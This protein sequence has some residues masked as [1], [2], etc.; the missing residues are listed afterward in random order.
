MEVSS[1]LAHEPAPKTHRFLSDE[2]L[3]ENTH[4]QNGAPALPHQSNGE[5]RTTP[6]SNISHQGSPNGTP[7]PYHLSP[8][9]S[10]IPKYVAFE[11]LFLDSP[12]YRARLPMRVNIFPH[13]TTDSIVTT[14][15]NF[16]GLYEGPGGPKGISFEDANGNTLIA[17][18]ENFSSNMTVFVRVLHEPEGSF[19]GYGPSSRPSAS[20]DESRPTYYLGD[21]DQISPLQP[22]Q[23]L[24]YGQPPSRPDSRVARLRSQSPN[25][26]RGR[27]SVSANGKGQ[28]KMARS[29]SGLKSRGSSTHGLVADPLGDPMHTYSSDDGDHEST[30]SSRK[31]KSELASAEISL[32]NIVEGG[33][34]KRAKFE[35]SELPLFVPP[36]IPL[37]AS[38]SSM[39]PT[40]QGQ[41]VNGQSHFIHPAHQNYSYNQ[42]LPSPM[43]LGHVPMTNGHG[44]YGA[45]FSTPSAP[46]NRKLRN[47]NGDIMPSPRLFT[48]ASRNDSKMGI[49]PTPDPTVAST[50]SDEDVALQL[51]RL[52]EAS[53]MSNTTRNSASTLDDAMSGAADAASSGSETSASEDEAE[54][55]KLPL[56]T[57]TGFSLSAHDV[58]H[59]QLDSVLKSS[60]SNYP[61]DK[62]DENKDATFID[63]YARQ[64]G[65][66]DH[67]K[68]IE[69]SKPAPTG[70]SKPRINNTGPK[71]VK[72]NKAKV[73]SN[74]KS[75]GKGPVTGVQPTS[76]AASRAVSAASTVNFQQ[77][78]AEDEED[79]SSKP[80][81][82]R[83]R[84]SKKGCDRQR[85]CQRCKDAGLCIDDCVSEDEGNGRKGR[86]GRHMGVVVKKAATTP[87]TPVSQLSG[88][89]PS[90]GTSAEASTLIN[91]KKRKR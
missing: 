71:P 77:S 2:S 86:Y 43:S 64:Q 7:T 75:K 85:P 31:A 32:D 82:Q 90:E 88:L 70:I 44:Q 76:T 53:M 40:R 24:T 1:L 35:S 14:V 83:C 9:S 3:P 66:S 57:I 72:Q 23:A 22:A 13:D 55:E 79:L 27:R 80:R 61:S 19:A 38:M 59:K 63:A 45:S 68:K 11:L 17:R 87:S 81:C 52:G 49:M 5:G 65:F 33:R 42:P 16:Y 48:G 84:K 50:I 67:R 15:K 29:R 21:R 34:R 20:I 37:T 47:R 12:N 91:S 46:A 39:S 60:D 26:G 69:K 28:M 25:S 36:Q 4:T 41:A 62:D 78:L 89:T 56:A 8:Q 74:V 54:D 6:N 30:T 73:G 58:K 18:Y 10:N 51:M